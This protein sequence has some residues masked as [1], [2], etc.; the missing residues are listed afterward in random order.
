MSDQLPSDST[1]PQYFVAGERM[2]TYTVYIQITATTMSKHQALR[3]IRSEVERL[4]QEIDLRIIKGMSYARQAKRHKM[5]MNQLAQLS[6]S[7][8][9]WFSRS[10]NFV[11]SFGF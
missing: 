4:N 5:L 10:M 2:F 9:S 1:Y 8:H 7:G 6:S 11:S 3:T